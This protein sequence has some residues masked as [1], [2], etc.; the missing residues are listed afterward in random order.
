MI[1]ALFSISF[2]ASTSTS[3]LMIMHLFILHSH[4]TQHF[5]PFVFLTHPIHVL[6]LHTSLVFTTFTS[7][8]RYVRHD[9]SISSISNMFIIHRLTMYSLPFLLPLNIK[10]IKSH[11]L[12]SSSTTKRNS[13]SYK[14][15]NGSRH[16]KKPDTGYPS[17]EAVNVGA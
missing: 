7:F 9:P 8:T 16:F 5:C 15:I 6:T 3:H 1:H 10:T 14:I 13:K 4:D 12:T 17:R 11:C 2:L